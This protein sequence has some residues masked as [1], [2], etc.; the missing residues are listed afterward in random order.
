MHTYSNIDGMVVAWREVDALVVEQGW[1]WVAA[2]VSELFCGGGG[3][4]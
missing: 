2:D 1:S 4:R 3:G